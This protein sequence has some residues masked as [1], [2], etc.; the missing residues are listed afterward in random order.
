MSEPIR[1]PS[2]QA[3]VVCCARSY[4]TDLRHLDELESMEP[5]PALVARAN[6][7]LDPI[8]QFAGHEPRDGGP[9]KEW[10]EQHMDAIDKCRVRILEQT[11]RIIQ[12]AV[13][14]GVDCGILAINPV[15]KQDRAKVLE[16][17]EQLVNKTVAGKAAEQEPAVKPDPVAK[18]RTTGKRMKDKPLTPKQS[19]AVEMLVKC[20]G[21][22][23]ETA[24]RLGIKRASLDERL[25]GVKLRSDLAASRSVRARRRL[26]E[27]KRGGVGI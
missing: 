9:L 17:V 27:D 21:N 10:L 19:E 15:D 22:K 1:F 3:E 11:P 12:F 20:N 25:K 23:T 6:P 26:P 18:R 8:R 4:R 13:R 5:P 7:Y 24:T 16:V 14:Y 2:E